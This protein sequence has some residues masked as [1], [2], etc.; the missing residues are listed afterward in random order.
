MRRNPAGALIFVALILAFSISAAAGPVPD[1]GQTR[2]YTRTFGEDHDYTI[3]PPLYTKLDHKGND[4]PNS[5]TKWAMVRDNVT[6]LIWEVK[7]DDGSIHDKDNRYTWY[8]SNPETNGGHAGTKGSGQNTEEFIRA[9]NNAKFGGFSDWRL[10][11]VKELA[12]LVNH[13]TYRPAIDTACFPN[14]ISF[15]YWSCTTNAHFKGLAWCVYF[16][17]GNTSNSEKSDS[18]YVRAVRGGW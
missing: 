12:Y 2:S 4:Q 17:I 9:I 15:G 6:G 16:F 13:G 3:N 18:H 14:T 11:T 10:P 1:T 7:T 5:A 8:D